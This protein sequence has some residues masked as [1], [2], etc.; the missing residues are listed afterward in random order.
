VYCDLHVNTNQ[1]SRSDLLGRFC[2]PS[3]CDQISSLS[4][5]QKQTIGRH[6]VLHHHQ[7]DLDDPSVPLPVGA[8]L[9]F[10]VPLIKSNSRSWPSCTSLCSEASSFLLLDGGPVHFPR[11]IV[12]PNPSQ[13]ANTDPSHLVQQ[14][15]QLHSGL[16]PDVLWSQRLLVSNPY[17][18]SS[19]RFS[20]SYGSF[21]GLAKAWSGGIWC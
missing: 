11:R 17:M 9:H 6:H 1:F 8:S 16:V 13:P 21:T 2:R 7:R 4:E 14:L 18:S 10:D 3:A 12:I 5:S 15:V 19:I 20:S